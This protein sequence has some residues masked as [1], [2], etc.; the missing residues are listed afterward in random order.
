MPGKRVAT[1]TNPPS[2]GTSQ[3]PTHAS[4]SNDYIHQFTTDRALVL[5]KEETESQVY[6]IDSANVVAM[7]DEMYRETQA[8]V[9]D[10]T[11]EAEDS[12]FSFTPPKG[13]ERIQ[14]ASQISAAQQGVENPVKEEKQ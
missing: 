11:R 8:T 10:P 14:F 12:T 5:K 6:E 13:A 9:V 2:T 3:P 4:N 1:A 7:L